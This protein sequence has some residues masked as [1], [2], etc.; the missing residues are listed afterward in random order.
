MT[1]RLLGTDASCRDNRCKHWYP[2][3]IYTASKPP[4]LVKDDYS[5]AAM[6]GAYLTHKLW[7]GWPLLD[8]IHWGL[9]PAETWAFGGV[10]LKLT[11]VQREGCY[12]A[13][14]TGGS[15]VWTSWRRKRIVERPGG[16][17]LISGDKGA[18]VCS[19]TGALIM[20]WPTDTKLGQI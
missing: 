10:H 15:I 3:L 14:G 1:S 9:R 16:W 4:K 20:N 11:V 12:E 2:G 7:I 13:V 17:T 6:D 8:G 18:S 19:F 5:E